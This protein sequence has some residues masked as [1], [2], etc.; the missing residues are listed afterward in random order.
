[1]HTENETLTEAQ[2]AYPQAHE[3]SPKH[4]GETSEWWVAD[5]DHNVFS[6]GVWDGDSISFRDYKP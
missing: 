2:K 3:V 6:I 1:M 5:S 4:P